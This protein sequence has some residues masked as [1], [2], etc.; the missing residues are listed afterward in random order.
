VLVNQYA[1][2]SQMQGMMQQRAL[3]LGTSPTPF[4]GCANFFDRC[5]DE[6]MGLHFRAGLPL[7]DYM[8]F[9]VSDECHKVF[10]Y[11]TFVRPAYSTGAPTAGHLSQPCA[12]PNGWEFGTAKLTIDNFG[13]YGRRGPTRNMMQPSK[14]CMTDPRRRLDGTAVT[15]EREWDMRFTTEVI[16]QDVSRHLITGNSSTAGQFD[17]LERIVKTGYDSAML[18]SIVIDWNGNTMS[19]GSGITWNGAA[20][21]STFDFVEVLEAVVQRIRQRLSWAPMLSNQQMNLGDMVL[22]MPMHVATCL[23][24]FY[25]CWSVCPGTQYNETNLQTYEARTFY[26]NL[27]GGLDYIMCNQFHHQ[28]KQ[29]E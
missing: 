13:R 9:E 21:A 20:V 19:G 17:G 10:E 1:L 14:Y 28:L 11:I 29:I 18:D 25:T 22:V 5:T 3:T 8:G 6:L 27:M 15:D 24:K 7:L 23:L 16:L 26:Q 12:D 2:Q 4:N